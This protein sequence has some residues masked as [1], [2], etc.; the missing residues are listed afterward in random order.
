MSLFR[1]RFVY[2]PCLYPENAMDSSEDDNLFQS[3]MITFP[4]SPSSAPAHST[5]LKVIRM[6]WTDTSSY[7]SERAQLLL[8]SDLVYDASILAVL[9]PA[10]CSTLA[11]GTYSKLARLLWYRRLI[12]VPTFRR[13]F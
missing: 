3:S 8:G 4:P 5:A 9:I 13:R 1:H 11:E 7:P 6:S 10:I 2:F 12:W